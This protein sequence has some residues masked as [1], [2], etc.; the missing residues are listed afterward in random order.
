MKKYMG[1]RAA[2]VDP[3]LLK[4]S[5]EFHIASSTYLTY[6]ATGGDNSKPFH[7]VKFPLT[8]C[9]A[10]LLG[11]MPEFVITNITDAMMITR[12]FKDSFFQVIHCKFWIWLK[13]DNWLY[14]GFQLVWWH[15]PAKW[16]IRCV[17]GCPVMEAPV[18]PL[19]KVVL[20]FQII[21]TE[22]CMFTA[23]AVECWYLYI[24]SF[25]SIVK[26]SNYNNNNMSLLI[27][28]LIKSARK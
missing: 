21:Q 8:D 4:S 12:R 18:F 24:R 1:M 16:T 13:F 23:W 9:N 11:C 6:L 22:N 2:L 28:R 5:L 10:R 3:L 26:T 7:A 25:S 14:I 20:P 17:A 27:Y 19:Y 15:S